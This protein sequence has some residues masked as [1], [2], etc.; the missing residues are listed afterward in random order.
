MDG[1]HLGG[2]GLVGLG[3]LAASEKWE[4]ARKGKQRIGRVRISAE[5]S[6]ISACLLRID[7]EYPCAFVDVCTYRTSLSY[8]HY[9]FIGGW[10]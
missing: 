4:R 5:S 2:T 6:R 9:N 10:H 1:R 3:W 8:L 7:T